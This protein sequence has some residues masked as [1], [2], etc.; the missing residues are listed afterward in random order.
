M[1]T[2]IHE[3]IDFVSVLLKDRHIFVKTSC[4]LT[5]LIIH[6][7]YVAVWDV[8]LTFLRVIFTMSVGLSACRG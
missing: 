3:S 2:D 6:A 4:V 7:Y 5:Q 8:L 1:T